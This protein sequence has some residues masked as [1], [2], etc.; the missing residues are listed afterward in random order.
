MPGGAPLTEYLDRLPPLPPS[1]IFARLPGEDDRYRLLA[2]TFSATAVYRQALRRQHQQFADLYRKIE[3]GDLPITEIDG[4]AE[5]LE[6]LEK[7]GWQE[8]EADIQQIARQGRGYRRSRGNR[9]AQS[10]AR[11]ADEIVDLAVERAE[12]FQNF[13]LRLLALAAE[14]GAPGTKVFSSAGELGDYLRRLAAE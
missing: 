8:V 9:V 6:T 7:A 13:R 3:R 14:R 12:L 1:G 4:L 5:Q 2:D 10:M 11:L